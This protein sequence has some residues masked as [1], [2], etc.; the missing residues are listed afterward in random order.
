[1]TTTGNETTPISSTPKQQGGAPLLFLNHEFH[2]YH[3]TEWF[4]WE[5][6]NVQLLSKEATQLNL[7]NEVGNKV[8]ALFALTV[9]G[10]ASEFYGFYST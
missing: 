3:N 2:G 9:S 10:Q 5:I 1:M 6:N 7:A 4:Q 8:K